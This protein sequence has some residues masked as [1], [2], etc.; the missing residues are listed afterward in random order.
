M[1]D[2]AQDEQVRTLAARRLL[3]LVSLDQRDR[4]RAALTDFKTRISRCPAHWRE[5]APYLRTAD[6]KLDATGAPLDPTG[7]PYVL[8][9]NACDVKLDE[10]SE[11][12]KK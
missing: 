6:L 8:D 7:V 2:D 10:R 12:P 1:Y 3:Q 11:I 9:S 5:F 4:L